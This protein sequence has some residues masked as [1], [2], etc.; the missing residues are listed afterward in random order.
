MQTIMVDASTRRAGGV[1]A[2]APDITRAWRSPTQPARDG[3]RDR[4]A[5]TTPGRAGLLAIGLAGAG[6]AAALLGGGSIGGGDSSQPPAAT[7]A[8]KQIAATIAEFQQALAAGDFATIC[9]ELFT[10][11]AREA[12]GG[13]R[14][15][16]VLQETAGGL[17]NPDVRIVSINVR[18]DT[19]SAIVRARVAGGQYVTDTIRLKREGARYKIVSAGQPPAGD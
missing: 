19:A 6:I 8:P 3:A 1:P 10:L 14:C 11:E 12:A 15:T 17:R 13:E 4:R 9:G 5:R 16:S 7:G 18:G 2:D